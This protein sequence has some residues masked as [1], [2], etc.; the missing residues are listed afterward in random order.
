[1]GSTRSR[2]GC[3]VDQ[4]VD[5]LPGQLEGT[6][7]QPTKSLKNK[8]FSPIHLPSEP[9]LVDHPVDQLVDQ[10]VD[11]LS[12]KDVQKLTG[13]S[14][15]HINKLVHAGKLHPGKVL[16]E[17]GVRTGREDYRFSASEIA[18]LRPDRKSVV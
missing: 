18:K 9:G 14:R 6:P 11:Q 17:S 13:W 12:T 4:L 1:M 8:E 2:P 5:Q 3:P 15:Q 10:P 16:V 7:G